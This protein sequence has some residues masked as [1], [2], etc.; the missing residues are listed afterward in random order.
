MKVINKKASFKY[1]LF[2]RYEAGVVLKGFEVK[3]VKRGRVD[4]SGAYAK[5]IRG[6]V[7][8]VNASINPQITPTGEGDYKP[9]R[10]RKL[11]L[12]KREIVEIKTKIKAKKLTIVPVKMYTKGRLIKVEIALAKAKR[13]HD[14]RKALKKKE[15]KRRIERELKDRGD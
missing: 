12:R 3:A 1:K 14:K 10:S 8:L 13:E 15:I 2:D 9:T 5:F 11:L 6:E 4:L 7:Y